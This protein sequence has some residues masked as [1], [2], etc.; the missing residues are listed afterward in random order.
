MAILS[1]YSRLVI[2]CNRKPGHET[3]IPAS[4][5]GIVIPGNQEITPEDAAR[6]VEAIFDPYHLAVEAVID[7]VQARGTPPAIIGIHSFTPEMDGIPRPWHI[8]VLWNNDPRIAVPLLA[9]LRAGGDL[10]VGENQPYSGREQY[11]Y[12]AS[13]H[14]TASGLPNAVIEIREDQIRDAAGIDRYSDLLG[15]ALGDVLADPGI[16]RVENY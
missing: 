6:R 1:G 12:S 13:I 9:A 10:M 15:D 14:A 16:Y 7:T 4:S 11:G 8:S 5:D 3:S 2:D